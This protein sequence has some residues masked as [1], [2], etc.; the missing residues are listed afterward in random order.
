MPLPARLHT[1]EVLRS[2]AAAE[3]AGGRSAPRRQ[4]TSVAARL[5][6]LRARGQVGSTDEHDHADA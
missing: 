3:V 5:R 2:A 4:R 1:K 6:A